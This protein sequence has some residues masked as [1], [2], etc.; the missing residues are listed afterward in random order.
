M[1]LQLWLNK[2]GYRVSR[3][4]PKDLESD[5][6]FMKIYDNCVNT[7]TVERMYSLYNSLKYI[8]K[9]KI[10]GDF[11]ECGVAG[12]E[13]CKLI[14]LTLIKLKETNR[15]IYL[16]DTYE[17]Q[18]KPCGEDGEKAVN[19]WERYTKE[20]KENPYVYNLEDV[21]RNMYSI[22]Y[23][24]ENLI[25]VKGNVIDTIPKTTP[26]KIALL[27]L[28]TDFYESTYHEL[29]HLYPLVMGGGV[30]L[31]DDYGCSVGAKKAVERYIKENNV[32]LLLNR[33]DGTGRVSIKL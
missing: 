32:R 25:F 26:S 31:I 27:R 8:I 12:G 19:V 6:D 4:F 9:N 23:P 1:Y 2:R 28:D 18:P 10:K 22:K 33:I 24:A 5:K 29:K 15:K 7:T 3:F 14:A 30:I 16:Y 11:V 20:E 13:S 17:G 21:K